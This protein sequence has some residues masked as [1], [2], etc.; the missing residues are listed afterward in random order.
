LPL[1]SPQDAILTRPFLKHGKR[2]HP[3]MLPSGRPKGAG[4]QRPSTP[5]PKMLPSSEGGLTEKQMQRFRRDFPGL[6]VPWL[7]R[8][9]REWVAEREEPKDYSAAFYGFM[10]H[11]KAQEGEHVS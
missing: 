2:S 1:A 11:K 8:E 5:H 9:F 10:R 4:R 6:D 7:E 3:K